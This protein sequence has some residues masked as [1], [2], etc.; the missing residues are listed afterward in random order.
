MFEAIDMGTLKHRSSRVR[1]AVLTAS[2]SRRAGGM[3]GA[4][5]A[6]SRV[7]LDEGYDLRVFGGEDADAQADRHN[8]LPVPLSVL[9]TA[10]PRSFGFQRGLTRALSDFRPDLLHVHGLWTYSSMV[11]MLWSRS[12]SP[13][14]ISPHGM[15]NDWALKQSVWKKRFASLLYERAHLRQAVCLHALS[16][17]EYEAIRAHGLQNPVAIIPNGVDLPDLDLAAGRP[18]WDARIPAGA[19]VLLFLGRLHPIKGLNGLLRAFGKARQSRLPGADEWHVVIAGW[20]QGGY[21]TELAESARDL[22]ISKAVH[23]VGPQ[24]EAAK[25]T[26]LRRADAFVLPS[27]SE[28]LPMAVLEAWA[29]ALPVVMTPQCNLSEGFTLGAAIRA[30]PTEASLVEGLAALFALTDRERRVAGLRGRQL[31]SDR[32][33]WERVGTEMA[34]LYRWCFG[35]GKRPESVMIN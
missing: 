24:F 20:A 11:S 2:V 33:A 29:H 17:G 1:V 15:L 8:W 16:D 6:L 14:L 23:F 12:K 13:T 3:F 21:Q 7:V 18:D 10:G 28:G 25:A 19:K 32:Y 4:L 27:L 34:S 30:D 22:G 35:A 26:S 31:V 9:P 5:R